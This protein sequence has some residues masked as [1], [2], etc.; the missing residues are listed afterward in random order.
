MNSN[1]IVVEWLEKRGI[2]GR[3]WQGIKEVMKRSRNFEVDEKK[4]D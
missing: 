3:A 4:D 2:F 1:Y